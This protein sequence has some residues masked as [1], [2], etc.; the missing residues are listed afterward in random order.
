M[1]VLSGMHLQGAALDDQVIALGITEL[2]LIY[3][4]EVSRRGGI[5]RAPQALANLLDV[6]L[7]QILRS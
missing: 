7:R 6:G 3:H 4:L 5:E 1:R 2:E